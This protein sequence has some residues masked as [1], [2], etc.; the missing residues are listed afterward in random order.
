M[1]IP[2]W[3]RKQIVSRAI[4]SVLN[5]TLTAAEIVV[6]DDGSDDGT[7]EMISQ[8]FPQV[9]LLQQSNK[10]VSA[11]R[12]TG[13]KQAQHQWI[14]LLDSD[15]EWLPDKL[16]SQQKVSIADIKHQEILL[17]ED[18]HCLR[19]QALRPAT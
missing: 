14:A 9:T 1:V 15:D 11:A 10:G 13:V 16:S 6:V 3:N 19:D 8:R 18:G 12:N 4:Q 7:A 2:T 5:Q 17:L